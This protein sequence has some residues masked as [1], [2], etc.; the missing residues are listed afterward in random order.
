MLTERVYFK[1][2]N[3]SK[4]NKIRIFLE[5]LTSIPRK[6]SNVQIWHKRLQILLICSN[7]FLMKMLIFFK[8]HFTWGF[9]CGSAD[10]ESACNAG[11]LGSIPGLGRS[12]GLGNDYPLQYSGLENS[13]DCSVHVVAKSQTQLS[14]FHFPFHMSLGK[15]WVPTSK[16]VI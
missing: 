14:D 1:V 6:R 13:M 7:I 9:P 16:A 11:D 8:S 5:K 4:N 15:Y 12:P 10:K 2:I 3:I